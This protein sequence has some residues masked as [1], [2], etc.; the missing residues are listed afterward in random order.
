MSDPFSGINAF[1]QAVESGNFALAAERLHLSRSAVGKTIARLEQRLGVSL[2]HRSTRRQSLTEDGQLYYESCV[3]ALAELANAEALLSS[4]DREPTGRLRI[5]APVLFGRECVAP[6][7]LAMAQ[8]YPELS[9]DIS[10]TDRTVDLIDEGFDLA[11]RVGKL[12]D[13]A[14]LAARRLGTQRMG[15]C[16]SPAYLAEH[17][18]PVTA[19]DL[20]RHTGVVYSRPGFDWPWRVRD[21]DGSV[22]DVKLGGRLRFDDMQVIADAAVSGA[23]L[24]WLPCWLMRRHIL[25]GELE[26]VMD[27]DQVLPADIH[28]VWP[29]AR[30]LAPKTRAAIDALVDGLLLSPPYPEP[31]SQAASTSPPR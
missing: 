29:K 17:G 23:G 25:A 18:R 7:L 28:A 26:L 5:S 30:H 1:V 2:F 27:S 12:P 11:V 19:E 13:S 4:G 3:R 22:H 15:I 6:V 24:A 8:K 10:F 31:R 14:L 20:V 9:V 21:G 16:A